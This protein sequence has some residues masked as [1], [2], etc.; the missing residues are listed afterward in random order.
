MKVELMKLIVDELGN[1]NVENVQ[2]AKIIIEAY[3]TKTDDLVKDF[4]KLL[5]EYKKIKK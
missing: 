4:L 1:A 2:L 3:D 5:K